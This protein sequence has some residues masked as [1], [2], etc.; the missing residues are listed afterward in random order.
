MP[1]KYFSGQ[2][3]NRLTIVE[4]GPRH[5]LCRCDCGTLVTARTDKLRDGRKKSC[6]CLADEVMQQA[7]ATG[8]RN[9][10]AR[11]AIAACVKAKRAAERNSPEAV[12]R[13]ALVGI[14]KAMHQRCTNHNH[15]DYAAYGGRGIFVDP[16]WS[17]FDAF[18]AWAAS[19]HQ[20]GLWLDRLDNNG[21][22]APDNCAFTTPKAQCRNRRDNR[23]V[24]NGVEQKTLPEV[25][26]ILGIPY[27]RGYFLHRRLVAAGENPPHFRHF[28]ALAKKHAQPA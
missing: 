26:E 5:S 24:T 18:Y 15:N 8:E 17:T 7:L 21:P 22:Y 19:R 13:R 27:M 2:K 3:F 14:Y 1:S 6:G 9:R 12:Q 11:R 10:Q 16:A 28:Q 4:P 25:L 23:M 20:A